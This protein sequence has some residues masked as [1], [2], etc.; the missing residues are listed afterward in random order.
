MLLTLLHI[1]GTR[2]NVRRAARHFQLE[3]DAY[4]VK[5][6]RIRFGPRK[7]KKMREGW[8]RLTLSQKEDAKAHFAQ[9]EKRLDALLSDL[10]ELRERTPGKLEIWLSTGFTVGHTLHYTRSIAVEPG[11]LAKMSALGISYGV[12]AYPCSEG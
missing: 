12:S 1:S 3:R 9:V 6:E 7:G 10:A 11:L 4:K 8:L 5:G 2:L